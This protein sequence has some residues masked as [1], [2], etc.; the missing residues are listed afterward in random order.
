MPGRDTQAESEEYCADWV[1][2]RAQNRSRDLA[3]RTCRVEERPQ[4]RNAGKPHPCV[5]LRSGGKHGLKVA[6]LVCGEQG[7]EELRAFVSNRQFF[8]FLRH[9]AAPSFP[10]LD[11]ANLLFK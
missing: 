10:D 11:G 8:E 7:G 9:N 4:F 1:T 2:F 6:Q 5:I 3:D